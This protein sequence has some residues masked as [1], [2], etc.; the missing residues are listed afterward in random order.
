M[1]SF[2]FF[3]ACSD[4][5]SGTT[6]VEPDVSSTV[7]FKAS[8][9]EASRATE[10]AFENGDAISVFAVSPSSPIITLAPSGNYADNTE[11]VYNGSKFVASS[12]GITIGEKNT[13]GLAY[14]AMYPYNSDASDYYKFS[15]SN[16]QSKYADYTASDL[17][18]AYVGPT[19]SDNVMLEFAHRMSCVVI[20][21]IGKNLASKNIS[22]K[23]NDIYTACYADINAN[24]FTGTGIK[25]NIKMGEFSSNIFQ[26][27]IVPQ[28][29]SAGKT[30]MLITI[31]DKEIPFS[32]SGN[33]EFQ[34]GK[35]AVYEFEVEDDKVI[36]I[37]GYI[38]PWETY[39]D[40][41]KAKGIIEVTTGIGDNDAAYLTKYGYFCYNKHV[42]KKGS[43]DDKKFSSITYMPI[44]GSDIVSLISTN[45]DN[46]PSQLVTNKGI[47]YFS[48]PNDSIL[49]LLYDNGKKITMLDSIPYS[50]KELINVS[51]TMG[52]AF[53]SSLIN[54][55]TLLK[56]NTSGDS[57]TN[58]HKLFELVCDEPYV[59]DE[60][61][62]DGISKGDTGNY[63]FADSI[64]KWYDDEVNSNVCNSLSIWTGKAT[65]KVG[66][67][68]CTLSGTIWCTSNIYNT[69]GTYGIICDS[70][71]S[72]LLLGNAEYEG[73]GYQGEE[74]LSYD[75]DFRGLKPNTTYYY[76]AYYKFNGSDHGGLIPKYGNSTD[77][78][79]Y[80]T[81]IK[82]F[83]TGENSLTVDVVMC[84]DVTGSMSGIINTVK[85]NA[86]AFYDLFK[87]SCEEEGIELTGL[88]SQV[89]A[90]RDKN[91]DSKWLESSATY[92]LPDQKEKFNEFVNSLSA[93]GGGDAPESGLE[94]LNM[95]FDKTDWG[96]DDGYHRQVIILWTD[97]PY[98]V[99]TSYTSLTVNDIKNKWNNMPS[100]RRLILFAPYGAS[101]SNAGN[102]NALDDWTN[103]IHEDELDKG[104]NNFEYILKSIIGELTSKA[105]ARKPKAHVN[106]TVYFRPN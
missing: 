101:Y 71:V 79:I 99:G 4:K 100:G 75:V 105:P 78:V 66:G 70:D 60:D 56:K 24:T 45:T 77:Q 16:N 25:Q 13:T 89:I 29:I 22:V 39:T 21:F 52:D 73:T 90:F 62:I 2:A 76:R 18:T 26:A 104:F 97:A 3:I 23:L 17:C 15:V 7:S 54:A 95:A 10:T 35:K 102:W 37:N 87:E 103:V 30:F 20:K 58:Y 36:A 80:D 46:I 27:I 86:I 88:N 42:G 53:K 91:V 63:T 51:T 57:I 11:Y 43:D 19:T 72:K 94:A 1:L 59:E 74:D 69:Y 48:F 14:Y 38:T 82:S 47:V 44:E 84:I 67:S 12:K 5:E 28:T 34:S 98:L 55:A 81:T 83:T 61:I 41:S 85:N 6:A 49:E 93:S 92:S 96:V 65:Y 50:K 40:I 68:S 31:N 64:S 32:F 33:T 9:K 106:E 8:I